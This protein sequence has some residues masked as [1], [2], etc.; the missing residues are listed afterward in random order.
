MHTPYGNLLLG[1]NAARFSQQKWVPVCVLYLRQK[2]HY[3]QFDTY[4][5]LL[6]TG[7]IL[8]HATACYLMTL[9]SYANRMC[10]SGE[11][12]DAVL[13]IMLTFLLQWNLG[14]ETKTMDHRK[15]SYMTGGLS[16]E[17]QIYRNVGPCGCNSGV[18]SEFGLSSDLESDSD[19][20][21]L[22]FNP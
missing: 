7:C 9:T 2:M 17:V 10:S 11:D 22:I 8:L 13:V 1:L 6:M 15:W 19:S 14:W 4:T 12:L 20:E 21:I 3:N 18:V 5:R 16:L